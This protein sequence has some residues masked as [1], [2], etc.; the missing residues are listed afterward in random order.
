MQQVD[1]G[2]IRS[3]MM[4]WKKQREVVSVMSDYKFECYT[5]V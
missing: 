3:V 4:V 2:C 5:N 1:I